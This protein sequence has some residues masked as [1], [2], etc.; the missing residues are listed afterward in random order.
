V[1]PIALLNPAPVYLEISQDWLKAVRDNAGLEVPLQRE[2]GGRLTAACRQQLTVSLKNF[3]GRKGWQPR[4][5]ARVAIGATGVSLRRLKLPAATN[6]AFRQLLLLQ[7]EREFPVPP[8]EL[9]WGY[10]PLEQNGTADPAAVL[11]AAV[12]KDLVEDY[13]GLLAACGL[14]PT[15]SLAA[16]ARGY[17]CPEPGGSFAMLD[18]G[19]A[20]PEWV[21]FE[22]GQPVA[23]RVLPAADGALLESLPKSL[24]AHPGGQTLFLTSSCDAFARELAGRLGPRTQCRSLPLETGPGRTPAILGL[25]KAEESRHGIPPLVLQVKAR[26][27]AGATSFAAPEIKPK[28]VRA[29]ALLVLVLALPYAEALLLKPHLAR[30]LAALKAERTRL[31]TIDRELDFLQF[32]KQSQPPYLD[33]L[34]LFA[35]SAQ[36]GARTESINMNRRGEISLRTAMQNGQQVTDFRSK[37]IASGF[38]TNVV[39]EEQSPTPDRQRVNVRMTGQWKPAEARA[40]LAIGP[41]AEEIEKAKTNTTAQ[42]GGGMPPGMMPPMGM[43]GMPGAM[44]SPRPPRR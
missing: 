35:K 3:V 1:R 24:D 17:L 33:T 4:I 15:F 30:R 31:A 29:V 13:A 34:F 27:P 42:A 26:L 40:G 6:A 9:A 5:R 18:L 39:V 20:R 21:H 2:A 22:N 36:P 38:F 10:R 41:T 37:L 11:V 16:L 43:P 25:R 19:S 23:V 44:P 14:A 8:E 32:L 12:R 28:L 7:I